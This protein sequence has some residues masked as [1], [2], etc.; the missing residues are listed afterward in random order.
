MRK[1]YCLVL[2][3]VISF[4]CVGDVKKRNLTADTFISIDRDEI[5]VEVMEKA[6]TYVE[7]V[8]YIP[9]ETNNQNIIGNVTKIILS[10]N[11][12]HIYDS[13]TNN[14][15]QF[16]YKGK[17]VRKI[18]TTGNGPNEY[19]RISTFS[20]NPK[21][22]NI[23]IYCEIKQSIIE[24]TSEGLPISEKKLG[25][26]CSDFIHYKDGYMFYGGRFPNQNIFKDIFPEQYRLVNIGA[27][28]E[29]VEKYLPTTYNE[30]LLRTAITSER[31]CLYYTHDN[32]LRLLE[33]SNGLVYDVNNNMK[34][35]YIVD[36]YKYT[37]PVSFFY[38]SDIGEK[39]IQ[40]IEKSDCCYLSSFFETDN[41]IYLS[42]VVNGYNKMISQCMY[43][44]GNA[45]S[46]NI[47][48]VWVNDID[49][50]AMPT[51]ITTFNN[52][53][54]GYYEAYELKTMI[55]SNTKELTPKITELG[56]IVKESDNPIIS[57]I[58]LR[59]IS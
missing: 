23:A 58:K 24:F 22:G 16:D 38:D 20:V 26:V 54:V 21:T 44:K 7:T 18:G 27:D 11:Y 3:I 55:D 30:E 2:L 4:S 6:S 13:Q 33:K 39:D 40:R 57:I 28:D 37:I 19:V 29:I 59:D 47:G 15:Y 12:I 8:Q 31:N 25:F 5:N 52:S 41:Y 51:I 17:F 46:I 53:L 35:I 50:I 1:Y 9:L 43:L 14:V 45:E 32:E 49:N 42:Y 48:P 56:K 34:S 10:S 36:F